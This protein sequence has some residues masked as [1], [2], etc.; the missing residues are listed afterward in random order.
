[1]S[2]FRNPKNTG[3][4][5][6]DSSKWGPNQEYYGGRGKPD[7]VGHGHRNP[8]NGFNRPPVAD[9]LGNKAVRGSGVYLNGK[10]NQTPKW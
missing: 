7:G 4:K 10:K 2:R 8:A 1:M 3:S 9:F 6:A 5:F